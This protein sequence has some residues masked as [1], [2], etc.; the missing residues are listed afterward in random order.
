MARK[1]VTGP[2][3]R[4]QRS[5][6]LG[7][8]DPRERRGAQ[9]QA[10]AGDLGPGLAFR[11]DGTVDLVLDATGPMAADVDGLTLR[12][13]P[14]SP[15]RVVA[16]RL[17]LRPAGEVPAL[18]SADLA[19]VAATAGG[20]DPAPTVAGLTLVAERLNMLIEALREARL[21]G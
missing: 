18:D 21:I 1:I 15:L 20:A 14:T 8:R 10:S 19:T 12:L 13:D 5:L 2:R 3:G 4:N 11:T 7:G 6:A 9:D 16:G 17:G